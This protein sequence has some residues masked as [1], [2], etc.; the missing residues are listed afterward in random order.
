MEVVMPGSHS[1]LGQ[2]P[3]SSPGQVLRVWVKEFSS[4]TELNHD[5]LRLSPLLCF[6]YL[7]PAREAIVQVH[8]SPN[9]Y[10]QL[11]GVQSR[12]S[13]AETLCDVISRGARENLE[14]LEGL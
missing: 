9:P 10:S 1:I 4:P 11:S 2:K 3:G 6:L 7:L 8:T 14:A 5:L 13:A 12:G